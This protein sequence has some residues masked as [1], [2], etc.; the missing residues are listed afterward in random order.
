MR[1][2]PS[3][4]GSS[5]RRVTSCWAVCAGPS[6]WPGTCEA[7]RT[8][9]PTA[10][11]TRNASSTSWGWSRTSW[12]ARSIGTTDAG[13]DAVMSGEDWGTQDR[14]LVSPDTFREIFLPC[15]RRL[16]GAAHSRGLYVWFHSCGYVREVI[17]D[18]FEAGIDCCQFDQ[19][20]LHGID[21]L[22]RKF[23]GRMHF[24]C[25]VDI[26]TTLQTRDK[27]RIRAAA[28]DY[29]EKLGSY[30][31]GFVAGYYGSNEALGLEP[32]Y[33]AAACE[34]FMQSGDPAPWCR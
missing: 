27:D 10:P 29:V 9:S 28:R 1:A 17:G 25:P 4:R 7:W 16:C 14:L 8:S 2:Q 13:V 34:A 5:T 24:W 33:Q 15:F 3:G 26:Q 18:W 20:E 23:G 30:G 19:P 22:A 32:E 21:L 6:T 31:G 12:S 11:V